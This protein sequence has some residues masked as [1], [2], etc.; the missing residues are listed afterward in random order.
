VE[1]FSRIF[2]PCTTSRIHNNET[3]KIDA[4]GIAPTL[5]AGPDFFIM[6]DLPDAKSDADDAS[7][8]V[9]NSDTDEDDNRQLRIKVNC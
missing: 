8:T 9:E 1:R 2:S 4:N 5:G 7:D 6:G 3:S